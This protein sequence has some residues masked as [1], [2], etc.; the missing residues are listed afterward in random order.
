V[1]A[2][3]A[4]R[5]L[6]EL[7]GARRVWAVAAVQGAAAA[8]ARLHDQIGERFRDGDRIVYLGDYFGYGTALRSTIDELLAFRGRV[9]SRRGGFACD[10]VFLRGAYEEMLQK[11]LE[12]Q[13]APNPGEVLAWMVKAGI[14]PTVR[15]YGGDVEQGL[16][17]ARGG[18]RTLTR[19]TSALRSAING[20]LGHTRLLSSLRHAAFTDRGGVLFVHAAIAASRPL[21]AQ[22]DAFWWGS[23]DILELAA[24][25]DGFRRV[26]RGFDQRQRGFVEREFAVSLDGGAGHGGRLIGACFAP[27]GNLLERLEA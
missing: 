11:L 10:V 13:F 12:L 22:G 8:L 25:F 5:N 21:A 18:P 16:A 24:P 14:E 9:L 27:N 2:Q 1:I 7:R 20:C 15:A 6:V 3:R 4:A 23:G 26:V 17:A 19:W